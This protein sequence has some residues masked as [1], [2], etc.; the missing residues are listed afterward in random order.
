MQNDIPRPR[1]AT[2][3]GP[4]KSPTFTLFPPTPTS[5]ASQLLGSHCLPRVPTPLQKSHTLPAS[6]DTAYMEMA[7]RSRQFLKSPT[8]T[9]NSSQSGWPSTSYLSATPSEIDG[10][11]EGEDENDEAVRVNIKPPKQEQEEPAWEMI[12]PPRR[13]PPRAAVENSARSPER[14]KRM[15]FKPVSPNSNAALVLEKTPAVTLPFQ[16]S[17]HISHSAAARPPITPRSVTLPVPIRESSSGAST[18]HKSNP[19]VDSYLDDFQTVE[20]SVARSVSV[21]K[22]KQVLVPIAG[23]AGAFRST[24]RLAETR[25]ATPTIEIPSRGHEHRVSSVAVIESS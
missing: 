20:I 21:S 7:S 3:P 1:R 4:A 25:V 23:K 22:R 12:T 14:A 11:T 24:E 18:F 2:S 17:L 10:E 16:N 13:H 19:S 6:P 5:K 8:D 15:P 9:V